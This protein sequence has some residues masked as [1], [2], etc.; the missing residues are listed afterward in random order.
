MWILFVFEWK[1]SVFTSCFVRFICLLKIHFCSLLPWWILA[2][3]RFSCL[4][5]FLQPS[6]SV[7]C[8]ESCGRFPE[9]VRSASLGLAFRCH[10]RFRSLPL[11]LRSKE[12]VSSAWIRQLVPRSASRIRARLDLVFPF[13]SVVADSVLHSISFS[14]AGLA[15]SLSLRC[16]LCFP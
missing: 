13:A 16:S 1:K 11:V 6:E 15:R 9:L 8:T 10:R 7:S 14:A 2:W 4:N 3:F 12:L 5:P